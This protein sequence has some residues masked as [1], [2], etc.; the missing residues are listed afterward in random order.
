MSD[1]LSATSLNWANKHIKIFGDT[2]IFPIPFEFEAIRHC[3]DEIVVRLRN[4][5]L[6]KY[7]VR[8]AKRLQVPKPTG[9]YRMGIQLDPLDA[10]VYSAIV[11]ELAEQVE[12]QRVSKDIAC[13][14]RIVLDEKRGQLFEPIS[15]NWRNFYRISKEISALPTYKYV[16]IADISD[17]YNQISHHRLENALEKAGIHEERAKNI[18]NFL[19]Q[20]SA[21]HH[22]RG[23]PVG[24]SGSIILAEACLDDVDK[25]LMSK[26]Y[27]YTR[28]VDDFRIFCSTRRQAIT[29]LHDFSEYL[30]FA[31]RLT[32]QSE[33]TKVLPVEAFISS[34]LEDPEWLEDQRKTDRINEL[35]RQMAQSKPYPN[36]SEEDTEEELSKEEM[37]ELVK[38]TISE[39]LDIAVKSH[40][41]PLG[42]ARY[43][44]RRATKLDTSLIYNKVLDSLE[45]LSPVFR[46]V[47]LYLIKT[48][49]ARNIE[50]AGKYFAELIT[51]SD[52]GF[53]PYI[54]LWVIEALYQEPKF[55]TQKTAFQLAQSTQ[56][57]LGF[58]PSAL[59]AKTYGRLEWVRQHKEDWNSQNPS[60]K[61]AIIWAASALSKDEAR[62]WLSSLA[63]SEDILDAS[64]AKAT[65]AKL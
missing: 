31:H 65:L 15:D 11:Y 2:D 28:Y 22:S 10:I 14:Y 19:A 57:V 42:L 7:M 60:D 34:E 13:S 12:N 16:V 53:L 52:I 59:I 64:I 9:G 21:K 44:L 63:A 49:N 8:P 5:E 32:L 58:R 25:Y 51:Q 6:D 39:L 24:P 33:K 35:M 47:M 4:Y 55:V 20:I 1:K 17:F 3:W 54:Q 26:D 43:L 45:I 27:V 38:E 29:A 61:R 23:I 56:N 50:I 41:L 46:D 18:E 48:S 30:Y 36:F 37:R 40:P 62:H